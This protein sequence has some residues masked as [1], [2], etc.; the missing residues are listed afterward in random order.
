[1]NDRSKYFHVLIIGLLLP[2]LLP[3][4]GYCR[5]IEMPITIDYPLLRSLVISTAFTEPF[6]TALLFDS[7]QGCRTVAV[8]EPQFSGEGD[9]VRLEAKVNI[10]MGALLGEKC[11][12]KIQWDG[13][14]RLILD[15]QIDPVLWRLGFHVIGSEVYDT[16]HKPAR[17][18]GLVWK[19]IQGRVLK[20]LAGITVDLA[21]PVQDL[22][23]LLPELFPKQTEEK[24]RRFI[25]DMHPGPVLVSQDAIRIPILSE[26]EEIPPTET[27]VSEIMIEEEIDRLTRKWEDWDI[28][29]VYIVTSLRAAPLSADERGTLLTA[30]LEARYGF[31]QE[32]VSGTLTDQ[33]VQDQFVS[34]WA[35][36]SPV[37]R[38]QLGDPNASNLLGYL[39]F[40]T[41]SDALE[42]LLKIGPAMGMDISRDGLVRLAR[43]MADE[44]PLAWV[45]GVDIDADLRKALGL[46]DALEV[47]TESTEGGSPEVGQTTPRIER[48]LK[49]ILPG[50]VSLCWA[51]GPRPSDEA[52][53]QWLV[54]REN[55][56]TYIPAVR[57]IL[58]QAAQKAFQGGDSEGDQRLIRT[59][60]MATAWQESCFRQFHVQ[61]GR[62]NYI[63]SYN[64]TSVGLMQI[65]EKV[66]RGLYKLDALRWNIRYNASAGCDIMSLYLNKYIL[67]KQDKLLKDGKLDPDLV[68]RVLYAMYNG[69]PGEFGNFLKRHGKGKYY[70]SDNLFWEKY[71][72][73]EAQSWD[74]VNLCLFG[75][76]SA[77]IENN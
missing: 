60:V 8:S 30:L 72:W 24:V 70:P 26:M 14:I 16:D 74:K 1:M 54:S 20:Y 36:I 57:G 76:E 38:A 46:G 34:T 6:N 75:E 62:L 27:A 77:L 9:S 52:L 40:F 17:I 15:P 31:V 39:S 37:F 4:I 69:G 44:R 51:D 59:A 58:E 13:Y 56:E 3:G 49:R 61:A 35:A 43:I 21:P 10:R 29:L 67:K 64:G 32:L 55:V 12:F 23:T 19:V 45:Y 33:T 25:D 28:F 22:K 73:V 66:W 2:V 41:A 5:Q 50:I 18:A 7:A 65:N 71:Q 47:P 53:K 68:S 42:S 48:L 11:R 63:R